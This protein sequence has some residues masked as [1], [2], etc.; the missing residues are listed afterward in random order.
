MSNMI[1]SECDEDLGWWNELIGGAGNLL[2]GILPF[3]GETDLCQLQQNDF[4]DLLEREQI[5]ICIAESAT[6]YGKLWDG[7]LNM[8][9]GFGLPYQYVLIITIMLLIILVGMIIKMVGVG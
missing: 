9:G 5:G 8:V 7:A 2:K 1:Y 4:D 6:W 3:I